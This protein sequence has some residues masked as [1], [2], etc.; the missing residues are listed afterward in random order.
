MKLLL[1]LLLFLLENAIKIGGV[2]VALGMVTTAVIT[3]KKI[4]IGDI[5]PQSWKEP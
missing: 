5:I 4:W 3:I 1:T 2:F